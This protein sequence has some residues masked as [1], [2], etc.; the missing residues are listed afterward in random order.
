M[1]TVYSDDKGH[2]CTL[3]KSRFTKEWPQ[4]TGKTLQLQLCL[5]VNAKV[6]KHCNVHADTINAQDTL[7]VLVDEHPIWANLWCV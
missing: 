7:I 1:A 3:S 2:Q 5:S 4:L 6:S